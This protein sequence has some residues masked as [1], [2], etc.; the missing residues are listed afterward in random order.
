GNGITIT[1]GAGT[2]SISDAN[3][4]SEVTGTGSAGQVAYWTG[5]STIAGDNGLWWDNTNKRLGIGSTSP[6][7]TLDLNTSANWGGAIIRGTQ[8]TQI[9]VEAP[10]GYI[11]QYAYFQNSLPRITTLLSSDGSKWSIARFD[12]TGAYVDEPIALLRSNGY[13]G[14]GTTTPA[15]QLHVVGN[16]RSD[17]NVLV[18]NTD[19]TA[20]ALRLFEPSGSGT[21]FTA[22]RAQAQSA[23]I[24]YTLPASLTAT[25]TPAS[26][27]LQT[28]ASGNLSWLDPSA[29]GSG[30]AWQL[31]GN[32][33][34]QAWNGTTGSFLGTTNTQPLVIAT[35]NTT[36]PQPVQ[37]WTNNTERMRITETGL[38]GIGTTA[39]YYT[40]DV[41][42]ST[43]Y[44]GVRVQGTQNVQFV[45]QA[46]QNY[47]AQYIFY[48][49][50]VARFINSVAADGSYW[51]IGRFDN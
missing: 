19:N 48:Q 41:Q 4:S 42:T 33:I 15:E 1:N 40:L 50:S 21:N 28:D 6:G 30:N 25:S 43:D 17:G 2:I 44:G 29:L 34:T 51:A 13:F 14:I 12:N 9:I 39:P 45:L 7:F 24:T 36:T 47:I 32:S 46:P 3:A 22:F 38:V 10:S 35:T 16:V 11:A 31:S 26:G 27:L 49:G 20:R 18:Q 37:F 23:D 5:A 8:N